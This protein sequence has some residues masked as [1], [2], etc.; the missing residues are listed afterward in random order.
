MLHIIS[1]KYK[2]FKLYPVPSPKTRSTSHLLRKILF[3]TIGSLVQDSIV[4][5]LFSGSGACGFEALSRSAKEI[6]LVDNF[7]LSFR[8]MKKNKM[9]LK[10]NENEAHIFYGDA[11]QML[12]K[13]IQK[14]IFFDLIIIDPPYFSDFYLLLFQY[15]NQV[16]SEEALVAVETHYK[17]LLSNEIENFVLFKIKISGNKKITFYKKNFF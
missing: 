5:D 6:Y 3:D 16:T 14:N 13:F 7:Y 1:G 15:L 17:T 10:L 4:L 9:K 8:I 12:K 2:G 11:F